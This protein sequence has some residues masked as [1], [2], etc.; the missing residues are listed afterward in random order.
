MW[1]LTQF[2]TRSSISKKLKMIFKLWL[3]FEEVDRENWNTKNEYANI[4]IDLLD[5]RRYGI[6]VWTYKY[7]DTAIKHYQLSGENLNGLYLSPPD[8]F[9]KELTRDCIE[10][11]ISDLLKQGNLEDLLNPSVKVEN[12]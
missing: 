2:Q 7:V 1:Q 12:N 10:Q 9:V 11:V 4:H 5:G 8:L 6:N 3:E